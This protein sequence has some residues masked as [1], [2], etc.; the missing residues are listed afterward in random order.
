MLDALRAA[1]VVAALVAVALAALYA[2][3]VVPFLLVVGRAER[4]G[5]STGRWAG[6]SLGAVVLGLALALL[7]WRAGAG[8]LSALPLALAFAPLLG[9]HL[10]RGRAG[11]HESAV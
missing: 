9:L 5:R 11:R 1:V 3:T 10:D 4:S 2:V 6:I 8:R 7:A